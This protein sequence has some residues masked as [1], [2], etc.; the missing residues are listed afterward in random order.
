MMKLQMAVVVGLALLLAPMAQAA[1][2][3]Y[4]WTGGA[5]DG[6]WTNAANWDGAGVPVDQNVGNTKLTGDMTI[7]FTGAAANMPNGTNMPGLGGGYKQITD[8]IR[9]KTAIW[10]VVI[11]TFIEVHHLCP[12][13]GWIVDVDCV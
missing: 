1:T 6:D 2:I 4:T 12:R 13:A 8:I 5:A 7:A 3:N 10:Y 9:H 11:N